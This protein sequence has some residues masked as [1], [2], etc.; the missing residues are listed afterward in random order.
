ML[1][2]A[3]ENA[4]KYAV[5]AHFHK[6]FNVACIS[7]VRLV[8]DFF[9]LARPWYHS[10]RMGN[11]TKEKHLKQQKTRTAKVHTHYRLDRFIICKPLFGCVCVGVRGNATRLAKKGNCAKNIF[12][13]QHRWQHNGAPQHAV[14]R[15]LLRSSRVV[16]LIIILPLQILPGP[17]PV[18]PVV[19]AER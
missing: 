18:D 12:T 16:I 19:K 4:A 1:L 13:A 9:V 8:R 7:F 5:I 15:T 3:M 11:K 14:V 6:A 17:V 10:K 2:A